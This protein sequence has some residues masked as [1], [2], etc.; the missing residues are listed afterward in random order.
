M[1]DRRPKKLQR[2]SKDG[3]GRERW[4]ADDDAAGTVQ[5]RPCLPLPVW[6]S[7]HRVQLCTGNQRHATLGLYTSSLPAQAHHVRSSH[8][9][10]V[11]PVIIARVCAACKLSRWTGC[12]Q[13]VC[14]SSL[15]RAR[16]VSHP[17]TRIECQTAAVVCRTWHSSS[18]CRAPATWTTT[19]PTTLQLSHVTSAPS[20]AMSCAEGP[21]W[22]SAVLH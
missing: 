20:F 15:F 6:G 11:M 4:F 2:F 5:V 18:A 1:D 9:L 17:L 7:I 3:S 8:M 10:Y 19:L 16:L 14:C 22:R 13:G 21:L 12:H